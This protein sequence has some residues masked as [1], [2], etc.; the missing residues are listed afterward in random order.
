M[1]SLHDLTIQSAHNWKPTQSD[2]PISASYI[3]HQWK[4]TAAFIHGDHCRKGMVRREGD[5]LSWSD[6]DQWI[7]TN[8]TLTSNSVDEFFHVH[9]M[10]ASINH[11]GFRILCW[12]ESSSLYWDNNFSNIYPMMSLIDLHI[13]T[14]W[15][16]NK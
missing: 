8:I 9:K 2:H 11:S 1:D 4:E 15:L 13:F 10:S 5:C 16:F 12:I 6:L 14:V 7:L 3:K